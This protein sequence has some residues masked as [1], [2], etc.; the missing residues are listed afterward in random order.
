MQLIYRNKNN[1]RGN[2]DQV[3]PFDQEIGKKS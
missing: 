3:L 1:L 2:M